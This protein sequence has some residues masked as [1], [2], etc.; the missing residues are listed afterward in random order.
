[1]KLLYFQNHLKNSKCIEGELLKYVGTGTNVGLTVVMDA[2]ISEYYCSST[3]SYGFK[4]LLHSPNEAPLIT[5]YGTSIPIG[6]ESRVV[7][8]PTI[9]DASEVVRSMPVEVRQCYFENENHL[10][11]YR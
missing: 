2:G 10:S 4:V 7:V 6:L 1:M 3:H 9:S 11:Y 5:N 8:M